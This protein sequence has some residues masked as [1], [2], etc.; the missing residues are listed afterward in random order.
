[1]SFATALLAVVL[2]AMFR[3]GPAHLGVLRFRNAPA[4]TSVKWRFLDTC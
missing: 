1:M 3:G 4:L 2:S